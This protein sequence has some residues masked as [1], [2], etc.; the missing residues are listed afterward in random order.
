MNN[1][2]EQAIRTESDKFYPVSP[3]I[4]HASMGLVTEAAEF[5]DALKKVIFY[6]K[7][8]DK[9]NL[10]EEIGDILWYLAIAMDE[11]GTDFDTEQSRVIAKLKAR[12][13]SKF[14]ESLAETRDLEKERQVLESN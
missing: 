6:G 1:F 5:Q 12:F 13:P 4:L 14:E 8:V 3:R 10:K 7:E 11:L 2:I 9:V